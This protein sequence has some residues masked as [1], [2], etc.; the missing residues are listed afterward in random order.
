MF[1]PSLRQV[2]SFD[3][4][5]DIAVVKIESTTPLPFVKLGESRSVCFAVKG[6][7]FKHSTFSFLN[8]AAAMCLY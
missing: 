3:T 2:M 1:P 4:L 6:L 7:K 5:S 8:T